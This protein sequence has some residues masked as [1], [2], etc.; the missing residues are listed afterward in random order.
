[1]RAK[2]HKNLQSEPI[3]FGL[4]FRQLL[5]VSLIFLVLNLIL[6]EIYYAVLISGLIG[7]FLYLTNDIIP[8]HFVYFLFFKS[9][10]LKVQHLL[11]RVKN[12]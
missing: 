4:K 12:D 8:K 7:A 10:V 2:L 11:D 5:G 3:V 9:S 6:P 1:M